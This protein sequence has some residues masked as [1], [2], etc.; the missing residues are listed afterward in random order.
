MPVQIASFFI[1]ACLRYVHSLCNRFLTLPFFMKRF[2]F[3]LLLLPFTLK[4]QVVPKADSVRKKVKIEGYVQAGYISEI[5]V[6]SGNLSNAV[7]SY[8]Y[9]GKGAFF[10][11]GMSTL[12]DEQHLLGF[13]LSADYLGYIMD[14]SVTTN[15]LA[16][17]KYAFLRVTPAVYFRV[18][19]K[20]ELTFHWGAVLNTYIPAHA[21]EN[22]YFQ[23]GIK[24]CLGYHAFMLDLG[25]S[26]TKRD[27]TPSTLT[28]VGQWREQMF[29]VSLACYPT[30][31]KEWGKIKSKIKKAFKH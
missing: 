3:F 19:T 17:T 7:S 8:T 9:T 28:S 31:L 24:A 1:L 27:I 26:F 23:P 25:Y 15:E 4:A 18:K 2:L 14:K 12:H 10:G 6:I 20:S 21:R 29:S 30:R 11:V 13:S 22:N 5:W 16:Q